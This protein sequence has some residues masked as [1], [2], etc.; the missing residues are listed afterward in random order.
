VTFCSIQLICSPIWTL[1]ESRYS[2]LLTSLRYA[3]RAV[4]VTARY[5]CVLYVLT[6]QRRLAQRPYS[7]SAHK[8]MIAQGAQHA[9]EAIGSTALTHKI[10]LLRPRFNTRYAFIFF[11]SHYFSIP[12]CVLS[13]I[14]NSTKTP[15][16]WKFI[17]N[18][19]ILSFR[20]IF[21][22]YFHV[23]TV[24]FYCLLFTCTN[25]CI[26]IFNYI[27]YTPTC[28]GASAPSSGSFYIA[29]PGVIKY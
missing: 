11:V 28:F 4:P 5:F 13:V 12:L 21:T 1:Y 16:T 20:N 10:Y 2:A 19:Q 3:D 27:T 29:F 23:H 24:H 7:A 17:V 26:Y 6:Q 18:K 8:Y 22:F 15:S 14:I 25:K 9:K